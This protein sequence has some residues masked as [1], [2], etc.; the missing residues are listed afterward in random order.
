MQILTGVVTLL[1]SRNVG[2]DTRMWEKAC[3]HR[4][5]LKRQRM[6]AETNSTEGEEEG[7]RTNCGQLS[8]W[9]RASQ[10]CQSR[11]ERQRDT[12]IKGEGGRP[13]EPSD[14]A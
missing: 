4:S 1:V 12:A 11:G 7:R 9:E 6:K 2:P 10:E 5:Y 3:E 13:M 8:W 14:Q